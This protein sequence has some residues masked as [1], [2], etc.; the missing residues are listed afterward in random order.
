MSLAQKII[1]ELKDAMKN[2][3]LFKADVLRMLKSEIKY[4]EIDNKGPLDDA[5]IQAL[6][7]TAIKKRRESIQAYKDGGRSELAEKEEK[8]AALLESFLPPEM[9]NEA[10]L[11]IID[12]VLA[13]TPAEKQQFGPLM[14]QVMKKLSGPAD[15]KKVN[16]LLKQRLG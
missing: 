12:E 13:A 14:G 9:S 4:K 5:G 10:I 1:E 7:R 6:I 2:K 11:K 15:G 16:A 3:D 8:E